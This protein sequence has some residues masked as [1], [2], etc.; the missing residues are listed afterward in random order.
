M[1]N[2]F[3]NPSKKYFRDCGYVLLFLALSYALCLPLLQGLYLSSRGDWDYFFFLYEIP[4]IS[5]FEYGQFPLWNPYCGGGFPLLGNPQVGFL[6][7]IVLLTSIFGIV[8]GLKISLLLHTFLGLWGMWLLSGH[9][10]MRGPARLAPSLIFMLA[11]SWAIHLAAGQIVWLPAAFLPLFFLTYLKGLEDKR[12]LLL[13]AVF[14]SL[15]FYEGGTYVLAFSILFIGLYAMCCSVENKSRQPAFRYFLVNI[16]AAAL[17][18][19]KLLPV[20]ELLGSHPR[21]TAAG[22][23][24]AVPWDTY[25]SYLI[26]RFHTVESGSVDF[27][28]Y[29]G[30][31][32]VLL[33]LLSLSLYKKHRALVLA[34]LFMFLVSLGNFAKFSPWKILHGLPFFCGFHQGPTRS[35]IIFGFAVALLVGLYLDTAENTPSR[36][37][38]LLVGTVM[39][40]FVEFSPWKISH[41]FTFFSGFQHP[42]WSLTIFSL[43]VVLLVWSHLDIRKSPVAT[44]TRV[45]VALVVLFIGMDL[46]LVS[47]RIFSE[48]LIPNNLFPSAALFNTP[49]AKQFPAN[50]SPQFYTV[51]PA[52]TT[53]LWRSVASV[54]QP[55]SQKRVTGLERNVHGAWSDQYL[56]LLQNQGVVDA[57]ETIPFER[58]AL[59]VT[60]KEYR[61]EFHFLGKGAAALQ[62]WSPNRF[63][64]HVKLS[65]KDRLVINQNYWPGWHTSRG[66]LAQQD[67]LLAIDLPSGEYDVAVTYLPRSFLI[68]A[69]IFFAAV[70]G[71]STALWKAGNSRFPLSRKMKGTCT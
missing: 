61:G 20:L 8:A 21:P 38:A 25:L 31:A 4:S 47:S 65:G 40:Y 10:G 57:Y 24:D 7:P 35:L 50:F 41:G 67:G 2:A 30:F 33:Y 13:A 16:I 26:D 69:T 55:F 54:H 37:D 34:A 53:A 48:A 56:P 42:A 68:G 19:P 1:D 18:A 32:V 12:W 9:L 17:S 6:S 29:F 46:F 49:T 52:V 70:A 28:S 45:I 59:A 27:G 3:T 64:Y 51:S 71:I 43:S 15:M 66:V 62:N 58:H 63:V 60:D 5:L 39:L 36:R 11:S 22:D 44:C 14:E 23:G